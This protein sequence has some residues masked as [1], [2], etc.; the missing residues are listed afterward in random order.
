M[1]KN[2]KVYVSQILE[3]ICEIEEFTKDLTYESF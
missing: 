1:K 2:F 3:A